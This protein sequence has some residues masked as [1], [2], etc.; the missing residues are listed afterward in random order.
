MLITMQTDFVASGGY[1]LYDIWMLFDHPPNYEKDRAGLPPL[2]FLQDEVCAACQIVRHPFMR[3]SIGAF[4]VK[5]YEK[6][7]GVNRGWKV[8]ISHGT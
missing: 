6:P 4:K 8:I 1:G 3:H 7:F 5:T 2:Q